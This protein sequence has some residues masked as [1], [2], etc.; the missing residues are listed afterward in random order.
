MS[1]DTHT[2]SLIN[3]TPK[4][5]GGQVVGQSASDLVGFYGATAIVQPSGS[6][7]GAVTAITDASGGTGAYTNGI[8]TITGTYNQAIL[9]NAIATLV[10]QG[11][12]NKVLV[13]QL[14]SDLVSL[15]LIKGSA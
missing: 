2:D 3:K 11:N 10:L 12:A 7:Q 14:R 15:G 4:S 9:A 6:G 8:L 5:D 1:L 13:N